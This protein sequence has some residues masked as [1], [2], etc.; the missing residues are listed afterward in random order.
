MNE[1]NLCLP[2]ES[3]IINDMADCFNL[4]YG[5]ENC[6]FGK[7]GEALTLRITSWRT[8]TVTLPHSTVFGLLFGAGK[9]FDKLAKDMEKFCH[10]IDAYVSN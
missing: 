5:S 1:I 9:E 6:R 10:K 8:C 7:I 3:D 2:S 4:L